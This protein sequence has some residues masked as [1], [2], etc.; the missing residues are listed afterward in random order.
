MKEEVYFNFNIN[1]INIITLHIQIYH[2][3][4]TLYTNWH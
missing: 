4:N 3:S 2:G 1:A